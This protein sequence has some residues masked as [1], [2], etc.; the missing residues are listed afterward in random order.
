M[1]QLEF[2]I[3]QVSFLLRPSL[4]PLI[5][6]I[7]A[8]GEPNIAPISF[9]TLFSYA[10]QRILL[11]IHPSRK[12]Y[13]NILETKEFVINIPQE[14]QLEV[15]FDCGKK[16]DFVEDKFVHYKIKTFASSLVKPVSVGGCLAWIECKYLES[17]EV[18][19]GSDRPIL[20]AE[21]V[22]SKIVSNCFLN[23]ELNYSAFKVL[24]NVGAGRFS[25]LGKTKSPSSLDG[26]SLSLNDYFCYIGHR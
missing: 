25:S 17:L 12:T 14:D 8:S 3:D 13:S 1:R 7:S 23:G 20:V 26:K 16:K 5:T 22:H 2:P 6:T 10:P 15:V 24:L 4:V 18:K 11:G 21:P 19:S 9:L